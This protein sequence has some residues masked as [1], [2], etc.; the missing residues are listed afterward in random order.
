[1]EELIA[2]VISVLANITTEAAKSVRSRLKHSKSRKDQNE[3]ILAAK[4]MI[5]LAVAE[6]EINID[7]ATLEAIKSIQSDH[8]KGRIWINK[9]LMKASSLCIGGLSTDASGMTDIKESIFQS[10][11]AKVSVPSNASIKISGNAK[12]SLD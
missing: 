2:F 7:S 3:A 9:T 8:G 4:G 10:N 12:M 6:G 1:M 5:E 11:G